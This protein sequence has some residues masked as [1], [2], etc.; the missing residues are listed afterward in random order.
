M[1]FALQ[2]SLKREEVIDLIW[3]IKVD[4]GAVC[5][6]LLLLM[7]WISFPRHNQQHINQ[8]SSKD[9]TAQ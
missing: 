6:A 2:L 8:Q 3:F 1:P 7:E 9:Q 4:E 5:L